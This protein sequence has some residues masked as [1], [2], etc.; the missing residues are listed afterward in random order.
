MHLSKLNWYLLLTKGI[1]VLW[2]NGNEV[3][4][5]LLVMFCATALCNYKCTRMHTV[6]KCLAKSKLVSYLATCI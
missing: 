1:S 2:K 3:M 6:L 5:S 4:V